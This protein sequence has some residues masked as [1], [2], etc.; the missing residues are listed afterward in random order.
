MNRRPT[1]GDQPEGRQR[2][3]VLIWFTI[4]LVVLLLFAGFAVD[5]GRWYNTDSKLQTAADAASK[6]GVTL[7]PDGNY[8]GAAE[9]AASANGFTTTGAAT[10]ANPANNSTV[11]ATPVGDS[12]LKAVVCHE[13]DNI[14]LKV[15]GMDSTTRCETATADWTK[16]VRM[17]SRYAV[18]GNQPDAAAG[19]LPKLSDVPAQNF[20]LSINGPRTPVFNG[21]IIQA[22]N[23]RPYDVTYGGAGAG[24]FPYGCGQA[25]GR[26]APYDT[27]IDVPLRPA[28]CTGQMNYDNAN[29]SPDGYFYSITV[30]ANPTSQNLQIELYDPEFYN[31]GTD[32]RNPSYMNA[33]TFNGE[34]A[35]PGT[36]YG[37]TADGV[38]PSQ[39]CAGD[40][41]L[42]AA[43]TQGGGGG[44]GGGGCIPLVTCPYGVGLTEQPTFSTVP[45]AT[46]AVTAKP[47]YYYG[48]GYD[49]DGYPHTIYTLRGPDATP[50][51]PN[52]NPVVGTCSNNSVSGGNPATWDPNPLGT[53]VSPPIWWNGNS[54][55]EMPTRGTPGA[56]NL[57][58]SNTQAVLNA[59][60]T[61]VIGNYLADALKAIGYGYT[62]GNFWALPWGVKQLVPPQAYNDAV[63]FKNSFHKWTLLCNIPNAA[64][65]EYFLQVQDSTNTF[66]CDQVLANNGP[67]AFGRA[68]NCGQ[69]M[70]NFS[71]RARLGGATSGATGDVSV[72]AFTGLSMFATTG[73]GVVGGAA[74][75]FDLA[76]V[77]S[78]TSPRILNL[79]FYDPG[80]NALSAQTM[81]VVKPPDAASGFTMQ[82]TADPNIPLPA[83]VTLDQNTCQLGNLQTSTTNGKML[84]VLI[85]LPGSGDPGGYNCNGADPAGCYW[86]IQTDFPGQTVDRTSWFASILGD[87]MRLL[88]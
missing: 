15:I 4:C 61:T 55:I 56:W 67:G 33:T 26:G 19:E 57:D 3:F 16:P 44:G 39:Y 43:I 25:I 1:S 78:S 66:R 64:A 24:V 36:R 77:Y 8:L 54:L 47:A 17:G 45:K 76:Q 86:R 5:L 14:F 73:A 9:D 21:D 41:S 7:L 22:Q 81:T 69:G 31:T 27:C 38:A 13:V 10:A 53:Q 35:G 84:S 62:F 63:R 40:D 30:K 18:L 59:G 85:S 75:V 34:S 79:R 58:L 48:T 12:A 20:W 51:R 88:G 72:S 2:G 11:T 83:G 68:L 65:G 50:G 49:Y 80:D 6:A 52:D 37:K 32:C 23:C 29:Y 70:N 74:P 28:T 71:I 46:G 60:T 87:P 82:C 42:G